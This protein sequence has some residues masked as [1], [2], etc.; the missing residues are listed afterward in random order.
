[1]HPLQLV[2]VSLVVEPRTM[3]GLDQLPDP[4]PTP[5]FMRQAR[6][7]AASMLA[8]AVLEGCVAHGLAKTSL[9]RPV[10]RVDGHRAVGHLKDPNDGSQKRLRSG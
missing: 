10:N 5:A 7:P 4:V 3:A 8:E 1:M 2:Q 9:D 6:S